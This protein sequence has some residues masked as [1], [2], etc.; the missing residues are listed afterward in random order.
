MNKV[1]IKEFVDKEFVNKEFIDK[2]F[3]DKEFFHKGFVGMECF[4]KGFVGSKFLDRKIKDDWMR[5]EQVLARRGQLRGLIC[6]SVS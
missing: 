3:L 5:V 4:D 6:C 1:C 2:V